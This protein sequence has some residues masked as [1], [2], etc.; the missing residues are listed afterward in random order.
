MH[1]PTHPSDRKMGPATVAAM[2]AL[3]IGFN[4][5]NVIVLPLLL[6][7][8]IDSGAWDISDVALAKLRSNV[9]ELTLSIQIEQRDIVTHPP[10][11]NSFDVIVVTRFLDRSIITPIT[12][13]LKEKG[14]IFYQTFTR[15]KID[16]A[17]PN[18]PDYLLETN[19][20]LKL[21]EEM[22]T[23]FYREDGRCG[24][25]S[26]GIRNEAMLVAQKI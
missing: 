18:N 20:L 9:K 17:G 19:E 12:Q 16:S 5:A 10:L 7:I 1:L 21:F 3:D 24:D 15:Q 2:V 6:G 11:A 4:F 26:R 25:S 14:I 8:G 13:S 22:T 23:L